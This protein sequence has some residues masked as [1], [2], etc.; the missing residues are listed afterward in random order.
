MSQNGDRGLSDTHTQRGS[1]RR[2]EGS[3]NRKFGDKINA[4]LLYYME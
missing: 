4:H 1:L 3:L 2:V